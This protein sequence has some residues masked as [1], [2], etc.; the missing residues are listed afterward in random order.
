MVGR[1]RL[2]CVCHRAFA[3]GET[4]TLVATTCLNAI[5]LTP[6]TSTRVAERD[7]RLMLDGH[8]QRRVEHLRCRGQVV[9][10]DAPVN[11]VFHV[12]EQVDVGDPHRVV[13]DAS[14]IFAVAGG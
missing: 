5:P 4:N 7:R 8:P 13:V 10:D 3:S 9:L 14:G 6:G 2:G 11:G 12:I 1:V